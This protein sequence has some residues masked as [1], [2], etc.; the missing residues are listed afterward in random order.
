MAAACVLLLFCGSIAN[1]AERPNVIIL[2]ADDLASKDL[3]C[4]GGP[5]KTPVLDSL[6]A[7]V[8]VRPSGELESFLIDLKSIRLVPKG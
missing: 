2:L 7:R 4:Y 1:A 8:V 5:V 3:G 6:A